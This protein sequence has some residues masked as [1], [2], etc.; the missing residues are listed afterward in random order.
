MT[1]YICRTRFLT[2]AIVSFA[3]MSTLTSGRLVSLGKESRNSAGVFYPAKVER[4]SRQGV[5]D[6]LTSVSRTLAKSLTMIPF[7]RMIAKTSSR[8]NGG[9]VSSAPQELDNSK[10]DG[11]GIVAVEQGQYDAMD[12]LAPEF[13]DDE[14]DEDEGNAARVIAVPV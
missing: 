7:L 10:W 14:D 3:L 5:F 12:G 9:D 11:Q 13:D 8:Q 6:G 2:A 4:P 1:Q